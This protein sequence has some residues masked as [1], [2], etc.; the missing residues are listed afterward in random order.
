MTQNKK[1]A[2]RDQDVDGSLSASAANVR[3]KRKPEFD[4]SHFVEAKMR[5]I[6][7]ACSARGSQ[8]REV[9]G[10]EQAL[11]VNAQRDREQEVQLKKS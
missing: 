3:A 4:V 5:Q 8:M 6:G 10:G 11:A 9:F 7:L 1:K 2:R